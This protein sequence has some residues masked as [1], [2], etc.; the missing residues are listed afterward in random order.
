[1]ITEGQLDLNFTSHTSFKKLVLT[2]L[3]AWR[4]AS[5][6]HIV[7]LDKHFCADIKPQSINLID[8][9]CNT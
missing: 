5:L 1:M 8:S 4:N 9:I 6:V 3:A 7:G 2:M